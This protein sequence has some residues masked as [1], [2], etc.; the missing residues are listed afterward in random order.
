MGIQGP[1]PDRQALAPCRRR[2]VGFLEGLH[3]GHEAQPGERQQTGHQ[4]A[5]QTAGEMA[6]PSATMKWFPG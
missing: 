5:L 4:T 6:K 3:C 2:E 1:A